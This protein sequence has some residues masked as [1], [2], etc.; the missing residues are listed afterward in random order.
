MKNKLFLKTLGITLSLVMFFTSVPVTVNATQNS[1]TDNEVST[2]TDIDIKKE[3]IDTTN[4]PKIFEIN[5]NNISNELLNEILSVESWEDIG[6]WLKSMDEGQFNKVIA[7][8]T[9]LNKETY[10]EEY[11]EVSK[12]NDEYEL[13]STGTSKSLLFYEYA[14]SKVSDGLKKAT[15]KNSSGALSYV[16]K[17]GSLKNTFTIK[18]SDIDTTLSTSVRQ[19]VSLAC[20]AD[21]G[22]YGNFANFRSTAGNYNMSNSSSDGYKTRGTYQRVGTSEGRYY[23]LIIG[24]FITKPSGYYATTAYENVGSSLHQHALYSFSDYKNGNFKTY[25]NYDYG[26]LV[27]ERLTSAT[28]L[29][30]N[31][32][33]GYNST[34]GKAIRYVINLNPIAYTVNYNGNGATSGN[35]DKQTHYYDSNYS[36]P[37][38][39]YT[40]SYTVNYNGNGGQSSQANAVANYTF[41]GWGLNKTNAV[42]FRSGASIRNL[43]SSLHGGVYNMY[44]IWSP[45]S[46]KL[47][48]ASRVGYRF[49]GW[50]TSSNATSGSAAN[51]NY[52][53]VTNTTLYATWAANSYTIEYKDDDKVIYRQPVNYGVASKLKTLAE[54]N[55]S[56]PGY[57]FKGWT[58]GSGVYSEGSTV[59]NLTDIHGGVVT[60]QASWENDEQIKYI[61]EHRKEKNAG[62]KDFVVFERQELYGSTGAIISPPVRTYEGYESPSVQ[63]TN[64]KGDGTTIVTYDYKMIVKNDV[65]Y[66]VE[67]Y[68]QNKEDS[69]YKLTKTDTFFGKE[70]ETVIPNIITTYKGYELPTPQ[71]VVLSKAGIVIKYYYKCSNNS[72]GTTINQYYPGNIYNHVDN[73]G[74]KY[75]FFVNEDGTLTIKKLIGSNVTSLFIPGTLM[76]NGTRY[77]VKEI[78]PNAFKNNKKIKSIRVGQGIIKI[79]RSAFEGCINLKTVRLSSGLEIIGTRA[80]AKCTKLE[81]VTTP[82]TLVQ[83]GSKAF[84]NCKKLRSFTIG[85]YVKTIGASA[86]FN[87]KS[88]KKITIAESVQIV[89]NKAFYGCRNL[90]N[91]NIKSNVLLKI[92]SSAFKKCNNK[93]KF[94]VPARKK[95]T[96]TR[97]LKNKV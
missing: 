66:K 14:L 5:V 97:L 72:I 81:K 92:G 6:A 80:F 54:L 51:S 91:V 53:P 26:A 47:P 24:A 52:T 25:S 88:L 75:D 86:F 70:G 55:I 71:S 44:A 58:S 13:V 17:K 1:L 61:V 35:V 40:R 59:Q 83:I 22:T 89:N 39:N 69:S 10:I 85:K 64:I 87:C 36:A 28:N 34:A 50:S 31:T 19:T 33:V 2:E 43:S 18:I 62:K 27:E 90:K 41:N 79:G 94:V 67:H 68:L 46:V 21:L 16:V 32:T 65:S 96:Y 12:G 95:K 30:Y 74:N 38:N 77:E 73:K 76:I 8:D 29:M 78:A 57:V 63:T 7:R 23:N 15:F 45:A 3:E 20:V 37:A 4:L 11:E 56:K 82:K 60:L 49:T 9:L 48:T 42:D 84:Y 93:I